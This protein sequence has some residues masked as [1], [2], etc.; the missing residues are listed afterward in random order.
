[1]KLYGIKL[2]ISDIRR[3]WIGHLTIQILKM[4]CFEDNS[5]EMSSHWALE[6][7]STSGQQ[8]SENR[9]RSVRTYHAGQQ[10]I[11]LCDFFATFAAR[12]GQVA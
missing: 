8:R 6:Q 4:A 5:N 7:S 3:Q 2:L 1:M 9:Q 12:K 10:A 11:A